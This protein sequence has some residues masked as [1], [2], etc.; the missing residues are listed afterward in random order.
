M[1]GSAFLLS[2]FAPF[3]IARWSKGLDVIC[4][5]CHDPKVLRQKKEHGRCAYCH[6]IASLT[7]E[8][9]PPPP[10]PTPPTNTST[11]AKGKL[12]ESGG[13]N[14]GGGNGGGH[15][16]VCGQCAGSKRAADKPM[17]VWMA[18]RGQEQQQIIKA[19]YISCG[20]PLY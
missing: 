3:Y 15:V 7:K 20:L 11:D 9:L 19:Y 5:N 1:C 2:H 13:S 17:V 6:R 14:A 8:G 12:T 4:A 18:E 10:S 16:K